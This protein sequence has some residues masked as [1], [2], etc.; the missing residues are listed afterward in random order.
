MPCAI[1]DTGV[2]LC[3]PVK[4]HM[5]RTSVTRRGAA[6]QFSAMYCARRGSPGIRTVA[7]KSPGSA[8]MC[9]LAMAVS[10]AARGL[11]P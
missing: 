11:E 3:V 1:T 7:A 6:N 8:F 9:L 10:V 4:P 5:L 2:P